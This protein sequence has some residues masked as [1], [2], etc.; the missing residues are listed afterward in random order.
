[1]LKIRPDQL[2]FTRFEQLLRRGQQ[3]LESNPAEASV[4]L[5]EALSLWRGPALADVAD[6][7]FAQA[8]AAR[9][10]D[11]HVG[12]LE[13]RIEAEVGL[14]HHRDLVGELQALVKQRPLRERSCG[15]LMLCL[16]RAGRQAEASQVFQG[17]RERLVEELGVYAE[18]QVAVD[19]LGSQMITL[20]SWYRSVCNC[21]AVENIPSHP[22]N[23]RSAVRAGPEQVGSIRAGS[24]SKPKRIVTADAALPRVDFEDQM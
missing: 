22:V 8:E 11:L 12:A 14:A 15:L 21:V 9:L 1:M 20:R 23:A 4:L 18:R 5:R 17:I 24:A 2:D 7:A 19:T 13:S 3:L 6:A 10:E 16:Y